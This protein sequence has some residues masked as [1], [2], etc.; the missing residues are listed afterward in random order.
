MIEANAAALVQVQGTRPP[1]TGLAGR[2]ARAVPDETFGIRVDL[3]TA[4]DHWVPLDG[5][6]PI[7]QVASLLEPHVSAPQVVLVGLGL[8]YALDLLEAC[9][10]PARVLAIEPD[11]AVASLF[12]ARRDWRPWIGADRLRLLVG[13]DYVGA[14][15]LARWIDGAHPPPVLVQQALREARPRT[16][17]EATQ[18][19][20]RVIADAQ[21]NADARRRFAGRYL[22]Q[23]IGNLPTILAESD[24]AVLDGLCPGVPAVV[25]GAGPS[26]DDNAPLLATLQDRAVIIAADTALR[27]LLA[28]GVRPHFVAGVD[29][30]ELN[31]RHVGGVSGV[32]DVWMV[33]EGSLHPSA[34]EPFGNRIFTFRV[35]QHEP[36]PW[37]REAGVTRGS[38]RAWGSVVTSAFDLALR[39]G[40]DPVVFAGTDL[41]YTGERPYCRHSIYD[42]IW[43]D[44]VMKA[45]NWT[46]EQLAADYFASR[47]TV[48]DKDLHG[49]PI[50]TA[51]HLLSFRNW[52][53]D[54][55]AATDRRCINA[56]GGGVL[57]GQA[58]EQAR[59]D[60]VLRDRPP[61][62]D[63][64]ERIRAAYRRGRRPHGLT[65]QAVRTLADG[66]S[67]GAP[68]ILA[69]WRGFTL[70]TVSDDQIAAALNAAAG[71]M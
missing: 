65:A 29:P 33:A 8:G 31:A 68:E 54:Q 71:R 56:T 37:L 42:E 66:T 6:D 34:F 2:T 62:P 43:F 17:E 35:S 14:T 52:L 69:R 41:A 16:A 58:V 12:L 32:D 57:F 45:N 23:S 20:H 39:L 40:C 21:A 3:R 63:L 24:A 47:E 61:V 7:E 18:I 15:S 59:L 67:P 11:P 13:P 1:L 51:S 5:R 44:V 49:Q 48:W 70:D 9:D 50:R 60:D 55:A 26:L 25:V 19:A 10:S 4:D 28:A 38:L 64:Q 27:P 46:F 53:L 22:L 30:S 36:W